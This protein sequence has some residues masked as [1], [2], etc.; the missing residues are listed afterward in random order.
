MM[1][2]GKVKG[3]G[4]EGGAASSTPRKPAAKEKDEV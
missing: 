2:E 1:E 4:E 3:K